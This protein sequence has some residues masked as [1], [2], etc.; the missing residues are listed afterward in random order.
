MPFVSRGYLR[1]LVLRSL[2]EGP[3]YGYEIIRAIEERFKGFY[4]PSAGAVYPALRAL[5]RD[6]YVRVK[7]TDRRRTYSLTSKGRAYL[8]SREK[9]LR[10][11]IQAFEAAVGPERAALVREMKA[12][13]RFLVT[14]IRNMTP[15]QAQA[16]ASAIADARKRIIESLAEQGG[17]RR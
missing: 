14:N 17:I 7:G 12:L 5:L 8:R 6:G 15:E 1:T 16:A 13:G 4:K 2:E 11:C 3:M 9:E 10:E